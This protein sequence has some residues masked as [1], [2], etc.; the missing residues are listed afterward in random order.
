[1]LYKSLK[2]FNSTSKRNDKTLKHSEIFPMNFTDIKFN[3][4]NL[5]RYEV[6][7]S[8]LSK[9]YCSCVRTIEI[10]SR[11][12]L[13]LLYIGLMR[14]DYSQPSHHYYCAPFPQA[15]SK[16]SGHLPFITY[17]FQIQNITTTQLSRTYPQKM[18]YCSFKMREM[19]K[20]STLS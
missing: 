8:R 6:L 13:Y 7:R 3:T 15:K 17:I 12:F 18:H 5:L 20:S 19:Q 14:I 16:L 2:V 4:A 1:M 10:L 9:T 11:R